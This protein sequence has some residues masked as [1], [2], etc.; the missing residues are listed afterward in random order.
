M[1]LVSMLWRYA[2]F[3]LASL[4]SD[5]LNQIPKK[6]KL[7]KKGT[8]KDWTEMGDLELNS[9]IAGKSNA[10]TDVP[11]FRNETTVG[12]ILGPVWICYWKSLKLEIND[13][14]LWIKF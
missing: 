12:M 7:E 2:M 9:W 5:R 10:N 14:K 1:D 8:V 4:V 6:T 13:M 3:A 11:N